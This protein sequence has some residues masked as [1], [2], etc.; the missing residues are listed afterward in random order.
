M[1][2][3]AC[4][5]NLKRVL[6]LGCLMG[7]G[8]FAGAMNYNSTDLVLVF[9]KD[10]FKDVEFDLGPVGAF[11][12]AAPAT[13]KA[14]AYDTALVRSNF[15]GSLAGVRFLLVGATALGDPQPRV[16]LTDV[17]ATSVPTDFTSSK[18]SQIRSKIGYIGQQGSVL[19]TNNS[20]PAVVPSSQP[21][22]FTY[23]ASDGNLT[24]PGSLGGLTGFP[25]E[26]VN[27]A[28]L[29]LYEFHISTATTRPPAVLVG[30]FTMDSTGTL[31]FAGAAAPALANSDFNQDGKADLLWRQDDGSLGVWLM[32]GSKLAS[33]GFLTPSSAPTAWNLVGTGDFNQDGKPDLIRQ[34]QDGW[35]GV[36]FMDGINL[37]NASFLNTD[38]ATTGWRIAGPK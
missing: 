1:N 25:I 12:G 19:T 13:Q 22:S 8:L 31:T 11:V 4:L 30:S 10:G 6:L 34:H 14:V 2:V 23:V 28:T 15:N 32:D 17:Y 18:F 29:A 36:W 21:G 38:R 9:R 16:W 5:D 20:L 24:P 7:S 35:L 27:P 37:S 26:A 3:T 33:S